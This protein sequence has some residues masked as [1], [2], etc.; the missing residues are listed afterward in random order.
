MWYDTHY[1]SVT[2]YGLKPFT[3]YRIT[4]RGVYAVLTNNGDVSLSNG[5]N[6]TT[7]ATTAEDCEYHKML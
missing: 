5:I 2:L 4:I 6:A 1:R 3:Q 7:T